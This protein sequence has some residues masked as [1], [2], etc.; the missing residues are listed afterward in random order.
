MSSETE[1]KKNKNKVKF[2]VLKTMFSSRINTV[3][4]T[5]T[6]YDENR[7]MQNILN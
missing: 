6:L 2:E 7:A 5:E 3:W 4:L 1:L